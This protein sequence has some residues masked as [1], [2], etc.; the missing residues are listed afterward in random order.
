MILSE[1]REG[2]EILSRYFDKDGYHTAAEHDVFYVYAT[3]R[4]VVEPDL[5]RLI[6]LGWFQ[7]VDTSDDDESES[8]DFEAKHY[9][10]EESWQAFT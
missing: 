1:L 5:S 2:L 8:G 3:N 7:D 4:P 6:K 10:P 9:N